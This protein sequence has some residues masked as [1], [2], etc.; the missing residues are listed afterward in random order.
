MLIEARRFS[1]QRK[2]NTLF[3]NRPLFWW[4]WCFQISQT[5]EYTCRR[6]W[7]CY[8]GKWELGINRYF[9]A[10]H[11]AFGIFTGAGWAQAWPGSLLV[12]VLGACRCLDSAAAQVPRETGS[13]PPPAPGE[14][15]CLVSSPGDRGLSVHCAAQLSVSFPFSLPRAHLS[16]GAAHSL[17]PGRLLLSEN[18]PC[19]GLP[20]PRPPNTTCFDVPAKISTLFQ[21]SFLL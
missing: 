10:L 21:N 16:L 9:T 8:G 12:T 14:A 1:K 7:S 17:S 6:S 3:I 4:F 18:G 13:Q 19:L 2:C 15:L 11:F 5:T 20:C